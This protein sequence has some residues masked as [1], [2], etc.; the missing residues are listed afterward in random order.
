[1]IF[2]TLSLQNAN[3][4]SHPP[5]YINVNSAAYP[6][7][8]LKTNHADEPNAAAKLNVVLFSLSKRLNA[9]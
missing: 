8:F 3:K 5:T 4:I 2:D 1:M 6:Y 9:F 7:I